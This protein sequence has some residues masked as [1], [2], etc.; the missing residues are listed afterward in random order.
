MNFAYFQIQSKKRG[1]P[2]GDPTWQIAVW[3][4]IFAEPKWLIVNECKCLLSFCA[5][6]PA[7]RVA[8]NNLPRRLCQEQ[9][10]PRTG[11]GCH[12]AEHFRGEAGNRDVICQGGF[13][14]DVRL[15]TCQTYQG[16][17]RGIG[18]TDAERYVW[19]VWHCCA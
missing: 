19:Q 10:C 2:R 8:G 16:G 5:G 1:D 11:K 4:V 18:K 13:W 14:Q 15:W 3:V 12:H 7:D 17:I 6:T 9:R